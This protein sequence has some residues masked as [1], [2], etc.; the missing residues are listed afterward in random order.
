MES[1]MTRL[2]E[3]AQRPSLHSANLYEHPVLLTW[4]LAKNYQAYMCL[5][6]LYII[7]CSRGFQNLTART[8]ADAATT[9]KKAFV[10]PQQRIRATT[11]QPSLSV[12]TSEV[13]LLL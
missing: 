13:M 12:N 5:Q 6:M 7:G 8:A 2:F 11:S 3:R 9:P 1:R 4:V 10:F